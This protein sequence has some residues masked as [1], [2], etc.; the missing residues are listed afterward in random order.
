MTKGYKPPRK[1]VISIRLD[2]ELIEFIKKVSIQDEK[3]IPNV[4]ADM[5]NYFKIEDES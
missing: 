3:T 2:P 4:I 5:I 1:E